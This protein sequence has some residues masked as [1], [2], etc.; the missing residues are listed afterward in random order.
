MFVFLI[1]MNSATRKLK[2]HNVQELKD[3]EVI[4][5]IK[6]EVAAKAFNFEIRHKNTHTP[7]PLH[8]TAFKEN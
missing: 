8:K 1:M 2:L 3:K 6:K 7:I 4:P 5:N